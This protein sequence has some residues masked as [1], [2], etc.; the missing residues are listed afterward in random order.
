[1]K[2]ESSHILDIYWCHSR[3]LAPQDD[4]V[5]EYSLQVGG[6]HLQA[7][8]GP[9]S[10][11]TTVSWRVL[12]TSLKRK[13]QNGCGILPSWKLL[14]NVSFSEASFINYTFPILVPKLVNVSK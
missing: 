13:S 7:L 4:V 12:F 6:G 10:D 9:F 1:M 8:L 11:G 5:G 14:I 3:C 2:H